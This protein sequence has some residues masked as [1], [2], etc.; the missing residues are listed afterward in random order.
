MSVVI[1][2]I[3]GLGADQ[4]ANQFVGVFPEGLPGGGDTDAL[5]LRMDESIDPPSEEIGTYEIKY[6]GMTILKTNMS[7]ATSK[8]I[9]LV[10]RLDEQW[11]IW[12]MLQA[13]RDI[14]YNPVNG[15][16]LGDSSA[17]FLFE[18]Q[19]LDSQGAVTKTV[20]F[21]NSKI[22][23]LKLSTFEHSSEEPAKVTIGL[24]YG[25]LEFS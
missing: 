2:K 19:T 6:R 3:L 22:K 9:E 21:K 5:T 25:S 4:L 13:T 23:S 12:D 16:A 18:M 1:D 7:E 15:T 14:S 24:I 20:S 10:A 8:E 17:R 11:E